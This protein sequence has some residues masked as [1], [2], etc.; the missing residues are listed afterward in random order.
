MFS[1]LKAYFT[2]RSDD[3]DARAHEETARMLETDEPMARAGALLSGTQRKSETEK[4]LDDATR[5][6]S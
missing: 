1:R 5:G 3:D 6:Q 4:A 2:G